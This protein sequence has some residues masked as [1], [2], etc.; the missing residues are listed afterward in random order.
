MSTEQA[1]GFPERW[2]SS[3][4]LGFGTKHKFWHVVW[5]ENLKHSSLQLL[6]KKKE[7]QQPKVD[8]YGGI[9][10]DFPVLYNLYQLQYYCEWF[11]F[12]HLRIFPF[13]WSMWCI[14]N[15]HYILSTTST[16][17]YRKVYSFLDLNL[18]FLKRIMISKKWPEPFTCSIPLICTY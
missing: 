6:R 18:A 2:L 1:C 9:L 5:A 10:L 4:I 17:L 12:L 13:L 3:T 15:F 14:I 8:L 7:T 16:Y 11:F